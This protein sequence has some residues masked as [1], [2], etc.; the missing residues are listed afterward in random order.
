[1]RFEEFNLHEA[2]MRGIQEAGFDEAMPVQ[3]AAF[4][5]TLKHKDLFVQS[6]TGSGKTA[7]FLIPIFQIMLEN[8][9]RK[10]R[11]LIVAPTRE[12][13]SQIEKEAKMLGKYLPFASGVFYGGVGYTHQE[14][15]LK[16]GVDIIIGTP[17][18]LIDFNQMGKL[19]FGDVNILVIDEADRLFDMGFLPDL[20]KI[21]RKMPPKEERQTML[22]SATLDYEVRR[23]AYEYMNEPEQIELSRDHVAVETI[24]QKLYHV[25]SQEKMR[26]LL[27]ILKSENP[28]NAI[29][30]TNTKRAAHEVAKR[31]E[32]NGIRCEYIMGDL[33]Q[34]KRLQVIESIKSGELKF[35]VATDVASRG[36]HIND[37]ELVINYDLPEN[38]ES[39]VHRIGRTGRVG[40]EGKAITLVCEKY[41]YGL[42]AVEAYTKVKI[43]V[44]WADESLYAEDASKGM[45]FYLDRDGRGDRGDR[46]GRR[47]GR[48]GRDRGDRGGRRDG[49]D[50]RGD[51]GRRPGERHGE[52]EKR[53]AREARQAQMQREGTPVQE[54]REQREKPQH[55]PAAAQAAHAP[56]HAR[57]QAG[58]Q[59]RPESA[60][61]KRRKRR[62]GKKAGEGERPAQAP[63]VDHS[64]KMP[65]KASMDQRLEYYS[66]KYG[67]NFYKDGETA[68]KKKAKKD[69]LVK[70]VLG[71]FK[72]K[73]D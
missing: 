69:S 58:N 67:D 36:L 34:N 44:E 19:E 46:G 63:R 18:R 25:G 9:D 60:E 26:L 10:M 21:I 56:S 32:V 17:G 37:L 30:F 8:P 53:E 43:P 13:A 2:L 7:A 3:E 71:I 72:K 50:A 66:N 51:R 11:A 61:K 12:L 23:I 40:K 47:D 29:I 15:L 62:R 6:Q 57:G 33:P 64:Q 49:R 52:R 1:M 39:Y 54:G 42:E 14:K 27:G 73:K 22:F 28:E 16:Q 31:L 45:R 20:K 24:A 65:K 5:H 68:P 4:A 41:V 70:K 55:V 35:L 48:G 59:A 38:T